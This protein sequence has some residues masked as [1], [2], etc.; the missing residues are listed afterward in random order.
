M[1]LSPSHRLKKNADFLRVLRGR[2][3]RFEAAFGRVLVARRDSPQ[4]GSVG[5]GLLPS[6]RFGFV[7]SKRVSSKSVVR[8]LLKRR[9]SEW[10]R[11][12]LPR[13][14]SGFDVVFLFEKGAASLLRRVLYKELENTCRRAGLLKN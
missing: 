10:I 13:V 8:N 3:K 4:H 7:V 6:T 14:Q 12:E 1:A 9:A 11:K 5:V 2:T